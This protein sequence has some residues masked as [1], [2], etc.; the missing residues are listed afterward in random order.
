MNIRCAVLCSSGVRVLGRSGAD[1]LGE[2]AADVDTRL[3]CRQAASD[4]GSADSPASSGNRKPSYSTAS[5][6]ALELG[7]RSR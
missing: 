4:Y 5:S 3:A 7:A 6:D 1:F 2:M